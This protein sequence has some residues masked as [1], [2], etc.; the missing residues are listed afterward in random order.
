MTYQLEKLV[1][2][3]NIRILILTKLFYFFS[4]N[5]TSM[6]QSWT[7]ALPLALWGSPTSRDQSGCA[8]YH[9]GNF[10][11]G[12]RWGTNWF[13]CDAHENKSS[14]A[15]PG[16]RKA[17]GPLCAEASAVF[18]PARNFFW[19]TEWGSNQLLKC[20]LWRRRNVNIPTQRHY[21]SHTE[22]GLKF[23]TPTTAVL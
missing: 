20:Q 22:R 1:S 9:S 10:C 23:S 5:L 2:R 3:H 7:T 13:V 12:S 19:A 8:T 16:T 4:R 11:T 18:S 6:P 21:H 17:T 14:P 15:N